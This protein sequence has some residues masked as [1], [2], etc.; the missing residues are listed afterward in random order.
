MYWDANSYCGKAFRMD[1]LTAIKL[2]SEEVGAIYARRILPYWQQVNRSYFIRNNSG[3]KQAEMAA[4]KQNWELAA[5]HW[6]QQTQS[7]RKN[8]KA[9]AHYNLALAA[10][11]QGDIEQ[12]IEQIKR[13]K[14]TYAGSQQSTV[15]RRINAY[16]ITLFERQRELQR[17]SGQVHE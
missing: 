16:L 6:L 1:K 13:A 5:N 12:A 15:N 17:I 11:M 7:G 10:E 3:F 4:E 9:I 2:A 14:E 8:M